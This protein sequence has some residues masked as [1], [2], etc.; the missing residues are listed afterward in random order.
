MRSEV[1]V[2]I[3]LSPEK[4]KDETDQAGMIGNIVVKMVIDPKTGTRNKFRWFWGHWCI[5]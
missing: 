4:V 3:A 2:P 5:S 1:Y